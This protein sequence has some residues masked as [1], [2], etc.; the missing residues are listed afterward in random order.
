M[1]TSEGVELPEGAFRQVMK[2][3]LNGKNYLEAI[4]N[5]YAAP[6]KDTPLCVSLIIQRGHTATNGTA[7]PHMNVM[8]CNS[9]K[10]VLFAFDRFT[11]DREDAKSDTQSPVPTPC[12]T[13]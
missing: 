1:I 3:Q 8:V 5:M 7:H 13:S 6:V 11:V 12:A 2:S 4:I 10:T 9:L